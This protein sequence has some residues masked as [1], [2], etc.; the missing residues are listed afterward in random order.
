M[1]DINK[2]L[3]GEIDVL[4]I[5]EILVD[6]I[7]TDYVSNLGECEQFTRFFGGSPANIAINLS[8]M[9]KKAAIIATVGKDDIGNFLVDTLDKAGVIVEGVNQ[10]LSNQTSLVF[11]SKS[12]ENPSFIAYRDADKHI[13]YTQ[14]YEELIDKAKIIHFTAWP[15]S[16]EPARTTMLKIIE[17]AKNKNK[18]ISFDPNYRQVLWEG[19][20]EGVTFIKSIL[21]DIDIVKPSLDDAYH[22]FGKASEADYIEMFLKLGAKTVILT[23]GEDGLIYSNGK[24]QIHMPTCAQEVVDTTGAGDGFWSGF[25]GGLTEGLDMIEALKI[26]TYTASIAVQHPGATPPL[27]HIDEIIKNSQNVKIKEKVI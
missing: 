14:K 15:I 4:T 16:H 13:E 26:G 12:K 8:N 17:V 11:V 7:S 9:G 18:I 3:D 6:F 24:E 25:Y 20:Q 22:I 1:L 27:L 21:K 19:K 23:L 2:E 5:G 10:S